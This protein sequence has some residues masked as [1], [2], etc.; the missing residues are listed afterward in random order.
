MKNTT[1]ITTSTM[2]VQQPV[3]THREV[4]MCAT[5]FYNF[6]RLA[7]AQG[8]HY[9]RKNVKNGQVVVRAHHL[10]LIVLGF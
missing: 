4:T 7:D 1:T 3:K 2:A 10:D 9:S 5:E 6:Q 8:M